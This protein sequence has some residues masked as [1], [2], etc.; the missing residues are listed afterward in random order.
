ML[1]SDEVSIIDRKLDLYLVQKGEGNQSSHLLIDRFR[2]DSFALDSEE[3][4]QAP[5]RFGSLLCYVLMITPPEETVKRAWQRGLEV[6]RYKAVDDLLA[7]N[8]EAYA[9]MQRIL[10]GR[11]L[12]P[13]IPIHFEFLDNSVSRNQVPFTAAFGWSGEINILDVTCMLNLERFQKINV[14]ARTEADVY[15]KGEMMNAANNVD[16]LVRC[17]GKFPC[18]NFADRKTGGIYA[19][20]HSGRLQW[21]DQLLLEQALENFEV[22][23][24]L[25]AV[26]LRTPY[27]V[28]RSNAAKATLERARYHTIGRWCE[29]A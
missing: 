28:P 9:G 2:F 16:F 26:G 29:A 21:I 15:P 10:F 5:S 19:Q 20:F 11:T 22:Q 1:T 23:A 6:G 4:R 27:G 24:A 7:H 3:S 18:V 13:D 12:R 8:V 14:S 17:V 25:Q